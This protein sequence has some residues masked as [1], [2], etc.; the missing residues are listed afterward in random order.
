MRNPKI[1][2]YLFTCTFGHALVKHDKMSGMLLSI[3]SMYDLPL[4]LNTT[5]FHLI[6]AIFLLPDEYKKFIHLGF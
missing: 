2:Q 3:Y 6:F 4:V 5:I 1:R